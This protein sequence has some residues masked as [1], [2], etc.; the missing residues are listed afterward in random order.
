MNRALPTTDLVDRKQLEI[1][2]VNRSRMIPVL[3]A[4]L[5]SAERTLADRFY[6][7]AS[8]E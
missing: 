6:A 5:K 2:L 1:R 8:V 4:E 7:G 3:K